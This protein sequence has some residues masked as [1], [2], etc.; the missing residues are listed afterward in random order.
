MKCKNS[1]DQKG[2]TGVVYVLGTTESAYQMYTRGAYDGS[3]HMEANERQN[4]PFH[5]I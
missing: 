3:S 2:W 1:F 4:L 5:P